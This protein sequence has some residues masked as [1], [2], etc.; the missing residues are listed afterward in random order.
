MEVNIVLLADFTNLT[1]IRWE[2]ALEIDVKSGNGIN[3]SIS[4]FLTWV[5]RENVE[6]NVQY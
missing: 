1:R 5:L 4:T 2:D 6:V 3:I